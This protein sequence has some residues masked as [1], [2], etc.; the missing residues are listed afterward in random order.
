MLNR[1]AYIVYNGSNTLLARLLAKLDQ[2]DDAEQTWQ[3]L[4]EQNPDS[5]EYY[6][7]F[8]Q[9]RGLDLCTVSSYYAQHALTLLIRT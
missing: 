9:N 5:Y 3:A 2:H 1:R 4:I 7:G 6:R 8:F